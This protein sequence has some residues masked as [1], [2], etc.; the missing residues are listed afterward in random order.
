HGRAHDQSR[1]AAGEN[2]LRRVDGGDPR[3]FPLRPVRTHRRRNRD[4]LRNLH[5]VAPPRRM[6]GLGEKPGEP[7]HYVGHRERAK[8]RF[9]REGGESLRD[10]E[11]LELLL[12]QVIRQADTKPLAKALLQRFGSFSEVLSA[13]EAQLMEVQGV[14]EAVAHHLKLLEATAKRFARDGIRRRPLLDSWSA[15][16]DY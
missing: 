13:P 11:L 7:P 2:S 9:R 12:F 4:R 14:G 6:K 15:V 16:I 5:R 1:A 3:P 10:Y 8:E